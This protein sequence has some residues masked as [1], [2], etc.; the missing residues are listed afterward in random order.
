MP[1]QEAVNIEN[2]FINGFVTDVTALSFPENACTEA[3]DCTF[4]E[5]GRVK[6]R[7]GYNF[8]PSSS[9]TNVVDR[10]NFVIKTFLWRD[11]GGNGN[12][13]LL[14]AQIGPVLYF[15]ETDGISISQGYISGDN[16]AL[17][18]FDVSGATNVG[19]RECDFSV[20]RGLLIVTHPQCE[21]FYVTYD[22]D[23]NTVTGTAI[24]I[25]IRD[26]VGLDDSLDVDNR[27][28]STEAEL[29]DE[30]EY[31]LH[32]QGWYSQSPV[33]LLAAWDSARS[34]MP[35]NADVW[36]Y[37]VN[38]TDEFSAAQVGDL[39]APTNT[40]APKGHFILDAFNKDWSDVSGV[41]SITAV[42]ANPWRPQ[43]VSFFSG[44][45][46]YAGVESIGLNST[47]YFSQ[48][49]EDNDQLG[50]CYQR[51]DPT[52]RTLFDLLPS[53]GGYI[54]IQ[55]AGTI[56]KLRVLGNSLIVFASNGIWA[57][58][59][60]QG[61]GFSADDYSV[62]KVSAIKISSRES[63]VDIEGSPCFW[64]NEGIYIV[65]TQDQVT[66][67]VQP[68]SHQVYDESGLKRGIRAHLDTV[69]AISK[70]FVHGDYDSNSKIVRWLYRSSAA[71]S[72]DE[73]YEY[74]RILTYN[75]ITRAFYLWT[76][77]SDHDVK[78]HDAFVFEGS[79]GST[80]D[81]Q[82]IVSNSDTVVDS[83]IDNVVITS[84]SGSSTIPVFKFFVSYNDGGND[85]FTVGEERS[86]RYLDWFSYDSSGTDYSSYF[87][88]GYKLHGQMHR[89]FQ[90]NY[91]YC[92]LETETT[93]GGTDA[94]CLVQGIF[95]FSNSGSSGRWSNQQ[96]AYDNTKVFR[97]VSIKR[98]KV[99]G[100]GRS[101]Q[102]RFESE[103]GKPFTIIG[104]AIWE[105]LNA[106]L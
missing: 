86:E 14:V 85:F 72:I 104:W 105:T 35:S 82:V 48:I 25:Q 52:D 91:L 89:F 13:T 83:N 11:V 55:E 2:N 8:E 17:T 101:A 103:M 65:T 80:E 68:I 56:R 30:H 21:P 84:I 5:T 81:L 79:S 94:G 42:T 92:F 44:R 73:R 71:T 37:Y 41:G 57:I 40:P 61:V 6:R 66:F 47:V 69:P 12:L 15:Y 70:Q 4:D 26:L 34:D 16:V 45:A 1:R 102:L 3:L 59:G 98:L 23:N 43:A 31:N 88:T 33:D 22:P 90:T 36:W 77:P 97:D 67:Q 46:W 29:T 53:D 18:D 75:F 24:T 63:F 20:A 38:T 58:S 64:N 50:K 99:R 39:P 95:E 93:S 9:L 74:D 27:P 96:Q 51:N 19:R 28:T 7:K 106:G 54:D 100:K 60:S 76:I 49:I 62:V 78:V 87:I 32:N 10:S